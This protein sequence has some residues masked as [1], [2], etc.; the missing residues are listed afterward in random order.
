VRE[1]ISGPLVF[2]L[3]GEVFG[4]LMVYAF[5]KLGS[6]LLYGVSAR[7]PLLLGSVTAFLFIVS[8]GAALW[9]AWTAAC[10]DPKPSLRV[11]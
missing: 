2:V 1:M 5:G 7:D 9:P 4:A 6:Q 3:A 10:R 11:S 8:M